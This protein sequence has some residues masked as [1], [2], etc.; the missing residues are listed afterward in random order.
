MQP[1]VD[2]RRRG[3]IDTQGQVNQH[4]T[5]REQRGIAC[6]RRTRDPAAECRRH[7]HGPA[8]ELREHRAQILHQ[9]FD[10]I[11]PVRGPLLPPCPRMS[12]L[13][14]RRP[15]CT[16]ASATPAHTARVCPARSEEHT[17]ELQSLMR[18]SYAVFCLKKNTHSNLT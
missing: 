6:E 1:F 2:M 11:A 16:S 7:H 13:M 14:T 3:G 12:R 10:V 15:A 9:R 5:R 17:S 8:A 18:T 4:E